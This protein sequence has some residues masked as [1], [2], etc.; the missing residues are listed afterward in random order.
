MTRKII[1]VYECDICHKESD[2][3]FWYEEIRHTDITEHYCQ[4]CYYKHA[5]RC[6]VCDG[7]YVHLKEHQK[8]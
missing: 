6:N 5:K 4:E 3:Y 1:E 7:L 8:D 2:D